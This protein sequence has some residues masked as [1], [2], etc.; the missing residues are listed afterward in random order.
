[1][2]VALAEEDL[3]PRVDAVSFIEGELRLTK[4]RF[5]GRRFELRPW[6][7][8][9][10][11]PLFEIDPQTGRRR[12]TQA[13]I[14]MPRKNGKSQLGA[15][16]AL[17]L[18][19]ADG[20]FGAEVYSAAGDRKQ[21]ALVFEE[22]RR[23]VRFSPLLEATLKVFPGSKVIEDRSTESIYR[24]VSAD[25]ALQHGL[26]PSGVI[27]DEVWNQPNRRLWEAL[28]TGSGVREEPLIVAL[29]T[30]GYDDDSLLHELFESG[31]KGRD[32]SFYFRWF[33]LPKD[34]RLRYDN[35]KAWALANPAMGDFLR[36]EYLA[37]EARRLPENSFRR[38]HLNQWT[39][40]EDTWITQRQ[41]DGCR[42]KPAIPKGASV[43]VGID[44]GMH[45]DSTGLAMV[46][47]IG[48][49][50]HAEFDVWIPGDAED[51]VLDLNLVAAR[52][53]QIATEYELVE[54]VYDPYF[55]GVLAPGM[56]EEGLP[57]VKFPQQNEHMCPAS[58]TLFDIIV[59]RK[60]R[61]G[62]HK[63]ARAHALAAVAKETERGWR[64]SK[65]ASRKQRTDLLVALAMAVDRA[66][67]TPEAGQA[68]Y[69][70]GP[71]ERKSPWVLET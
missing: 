10:V 20:I 62:G 5:A 37:E 49:E 44:A 9:I 50:F 70:V 17:K 69:R 12:Y 31:R 19:V 3:L 21:A 67:R 64:I 53:R 63:V 51:E 18:L 54:C 4:D 71:K 65:A 41:W 36:E 7:R 6:Q 30:A 61:H 28:T 58:Q 16:I 46:A 11:E 14:G 22:A 66:S 47:K 68:V 26:N 56:E 40:Q 15:A 45:H 25:A 24:V 33:G 27:F 2:A 42:G 59:N 34:S 8:E 29:T 52:V 43:W 1:M 13:L 35:P 38:W 23:M 57:M 48:D 32:P 60:L 39:A 55:M